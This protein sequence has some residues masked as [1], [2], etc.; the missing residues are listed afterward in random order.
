MRL[1]CGADKKD[2]GEILVNGKPIQIRTALTAVDAGRQLCRDGKQF[3]LC[4][5]LS[6]A[7]N[8]ALPTLDAFAIK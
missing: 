6:M 2:S 8:V 1:I 5:G 3:G 7:D 4:L